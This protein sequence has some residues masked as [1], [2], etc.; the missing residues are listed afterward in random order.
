MNKKKLEQFVI[1]CRKMADGCGEMMDASVNDWAFKTDM[2]RSRKDF[3]NSAKIVEAAINESTIKVF[4]SNLRLKLLSLK[5][6]RHEE[7]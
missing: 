7:C 2:E 4:L 3:L 1:N 5:P 6:T